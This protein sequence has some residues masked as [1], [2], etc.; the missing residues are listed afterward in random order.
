[1]SLNIQS[2]SIPERLRSPLT[3]EQVEEQTTS[4]FTPKFNPFLNFF[5]FD[6]NR[7]IISNINQIAVAAQNVADNPQFNSLTES[8]QNLVIEVANRVSSLINEAKIQDAVDDNRMIVLI[9]DVN[10]AIEACIESIKPSRFALEEEILNF[11][12]DEELTVTFIDFF[13]NFLSSSSN[14]LT[15]AAQKLA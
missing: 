5:V 8:G 7:S 9:T 4:H 3:F 2:I 6:S 12:G 14:V 1:M 11:N 13:V 15:A 10:S